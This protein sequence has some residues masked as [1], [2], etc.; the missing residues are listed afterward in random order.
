[1]S[2]LTWQSRFHGSIAVIALEGELDL[3]SVGEVEG[4]IDRLLE[5]AKPTALVLDLH[6]LAFMDS[7]GLRSVILA[8]QRLRE[9]GTRFALVA[10]PE[11]VHR[12]FEITRMADRFEFVDDPADLEGAA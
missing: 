8:E 12:V 7:S 5:Q 3:A 10:G 6:E 11:P 2:A 4:E 1:M 9:H